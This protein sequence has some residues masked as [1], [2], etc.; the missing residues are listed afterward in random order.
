MR[1]L[2]FGANGQDGHYLAFKC[3]E[4][5]AQVLGVS[6]SG[7]WHHAD[8]TCW[9]QVEKI[10]SSYQPSHVFNLAAHSSTRHDLVFKNHEVISTGTLNVLEAVKN[11]CPSAKV[12]IAGSALQF[13][14]EGKPIS[15]SDPFEA[16]SPY[17]VSRIQSVYAARYYRTL[18]LKVYVGYLFHHESK[19]RK[20]GHVSQRIALFAKKL[21][22]GS[23]ETLTL[24]DISVEKE[25]TFA[26]DVVD[27]ILLLVNQSN[28]FEAVIGSGKAYSIQDWIEACFSIISMDWQEYILTQKDFVPEYKRIVSNPRVISTLGWQPKVDIVNLAEKMLDLQ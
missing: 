21:S 12:F 27:A 14:N 17:S 16:L 10:I 20:P 18:G 19:L 6:R 25:W 28:I 2:I 24:G 13:K 23:D 11:H 8:I 1:A 4:L 26:G 22:R 9:E 3:K 5:G 15:E 7:Q